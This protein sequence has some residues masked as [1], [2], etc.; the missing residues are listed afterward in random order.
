MQPGPCVGEELTMEFA[1]P[2]KVRFGV[3]VRES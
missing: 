1:L 3:K 2:T